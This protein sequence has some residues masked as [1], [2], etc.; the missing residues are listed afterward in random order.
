MQ[1]SPTRG[2]PHQPTVL[3]FAGTRKGLAVLLRVA[4]EFSVLPKPLQSAILWQSLQQSATV[5]CEVA[6][7]HAV[8]GFSRAVVA[9]ERIV[10]A[11]LDHS[12]QQH[13]P[14]GT[15]ER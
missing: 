15:M 14:D 3:P 11:E 6:P 13:W 5:S 8:L 9:L 4:H 10:T 2:T 1:V 12:C 7:V